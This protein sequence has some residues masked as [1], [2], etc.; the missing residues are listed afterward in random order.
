MPETRLLLCTNIYAFLSAPSGHRMN[1]LLEFFSKVTAFKCLDVSLRNTLN[2]ITCIC[3]CFRYIFPLMHSPSPSEKNWCT[4]RNYRKT[5]SLNVFFF[6]YYSCSLW[7]EVE[8]E[9]TPPTAF[10]HSRPLPHPTR[11]VRWKKWK[12]LVAVCTRKMFAP[13]PPIGGP[14]CHSKVTSKVCKAHKTQRETLATPKVNKGR[15]VFT[16]GVNL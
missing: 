1:E 12:D 15:E 8:S 9:R 4:R 14:K 5:A 6:Y 10:F 7:Y 3:G 16:E 2:S 11:L 13:S